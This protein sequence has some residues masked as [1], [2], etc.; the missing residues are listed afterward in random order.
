VS[1][2]DHIKN[3]LPQL[4]ALGSTPL[5]PAELS[6]VL[7]QLVA[8]LESLPE[9]K[10]P[11]D[12]LKKAGAWPEKPLTGGTS[13]SPIYVKAPSLLDFVNVP[14]PV[15]KAQIDESTTKNASGHTVIAV[16]G[17]STP[18]TSTTPAGR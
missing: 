4:Q 2:T 8:L 18:A 15:L 10:A 1:H 11:L 5:S 6:R 13:T 3:L 16:A 7:A 9:G 17:V 12:A 14:A